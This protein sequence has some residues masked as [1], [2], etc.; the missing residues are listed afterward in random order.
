MVSMRISATTTSSALSRGFTLLEVL[1][2]V[3]LLALLAAVAA[4]VMVNRLGD[5]DM[6]RE[7][8]KLT[9]R[10]YQL[11]EQSLFLG[12]LLAARLEEDGLQP[13]RYSL[14]ER[15]FVPTAA[16]SG[17]VSALELPPGIRLEW[18]LEELEGDEPELA[19]A[20]SAR[21]ADGDDDDADRNSSGDER[22]N[23]DAGR[24]DDGGE[25]ENGEAEAPQLYFFPSG[26]V[27][28]A[29]L[30]LRAVD[31]NGEGDVRLELDALGGVH[32]PGQQ[33]GDTDEG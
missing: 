25:D 13:L 9:A 33:E 1:V 6:A 3:S 2:V 19:D 17:S 30:W 27:S 26:E 28:P 20:V 24:D 15:E 21:L 32:R 18:R 16:G 7:A 11:N 8:E 4:P 31:G 29:T 12:Q 22:N 5:D 10:L 14:E 23:D